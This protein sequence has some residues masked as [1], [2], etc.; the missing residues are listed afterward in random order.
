M[1]E[2]RLIEDGSLWADQ[3]GFTFGLRL[4]WYRALP[5]SSVAQLDIEIDGTAIQPHAV[6][7]ITEDGD[8]H[9]LEALADHP[10]DWW[11]VTDTA[12]IRVDHPGGLEP[13]KHD[14]AVTLGT[15]IPY[16]VLR[17]PDVL[18]IVESCHKQLT[19]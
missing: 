9:G 3:D 8:A 15:R 17:P 5:L 2:N 6:T 16:V 11:F 12:R 19:V 18:V 10:D 1:F 4:N 14:L 7:F 13:G